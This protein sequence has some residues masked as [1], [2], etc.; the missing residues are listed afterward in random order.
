MKNIIFKNYSFG[1]KQW[2]VS[3]AEDS[4]VKKMIKILTNLFIWHRILKKQSFPGISMKKI[5]FP[6]SVKV[7]ETKAIGKIESLTLIL[8]INTL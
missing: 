2:Y 8:L 4:E 6:P 5:L 3:F 1:S 7:I